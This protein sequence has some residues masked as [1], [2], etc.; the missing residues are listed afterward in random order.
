MKIPSARKHRLHIDVAG[1]ITKNCLYL[2]S[3]INYQTWIEFRNRTKINEILANDATKIDEKTASE[4]VNNMNLSDNEEITNNKLLPFFVNKTKRQIQHSIFANKRKYRSLPLLFGIK[5]EADL[6][7]MKTINCVS[8]ENI[9]IIDKYQIKCTEFQRYIFQDIQWINEQKRFNTKMITLQQYHTISIIDTLNARK[10][11]YFKMNNVNISDGETVMISPYNNNESS[12]ISNF[13]CKVI[14]LSAFNEVHAMHRKDSPYCFRLDGDETDYTITCHLSSNNQRHEWI[15]HLDYVIHDQLSLV[16]Q[17]TVRFMDKDNVKMKMMNDFTHNSEMKDNEGYSTNFSFG[18]YLNYWEDKEDN[19]VIPKYET[20]KEELINN[21]HATIT[22]KQYYGLYKECRALY[23]K[24]KKEIQLL[25]AQD[26]GVN[27]KKYN[28]PKGTPITI[29]HLIALKLYTDYTNTQMELRRH[30]RKCNESESLKDFIKRNS[31]IAHW[32][33]YLKECCT[34]YGKVM[35]SKMVVFTGLKQK[36]MFDSMQQHFQCPLS[37]TI[38]VN[39][40]NQFADGSN[41]IILMM[42]RANP[43]TRYVHKT[44]T[45]I[46]IIC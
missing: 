20:L 11:E 2:I 9:D 8:I 22:E 24:K 27:N 16:R 41:G 25:K 42:K 43:K 46:Q 35:S 14:E 4:L 23:I 21:K 45:L 12:D 29:N 5:D 31:E 7:H 3:A 33:R 38:D 26:I 19:S 39:I 44:Y 37:T 17:K 13:K 15:T 28:V 10:D 30:C 32:C 6:S 40:A 36:L 1:L 34:F 18:M